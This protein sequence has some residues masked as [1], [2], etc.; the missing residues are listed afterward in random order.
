VFQGVGAVAKTWGSSND[1]FIDLRDGRRIRISLELFNPVTDDEDKTTQ[2]L[3]QWVSSQRDE[4]ALGC[5][6]GDSTWGSEDLEDG[7]G[8]FGVESECATPEIDEGEVLEKSLMVMNSDE[9]AEL[10][11]IEAVGVDS[12]DDLEI[13][14][15]DVMRR[16]EMVPI[17]VEPLAVAL[18]DGMESV[19]AEEDSFSGKKTFDWVMRKEKGIEKV[20]GASY[21]GYE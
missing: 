11:L 5:T 3:I 7:F 14:G 21:K 20:L 10:M 12:V 15:G 1:W 8:I 4:G 18:P 2:K 17:S 9:N 13:D 16:E 6:E 19:R